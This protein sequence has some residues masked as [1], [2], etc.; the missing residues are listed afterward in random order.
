[1]TK[2]D[3]AVH[4]GPVCIAVSCS[5]RFAGDFITATIDGADVA[6]AVWMKDG[7]TPTIRYARP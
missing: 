5:N 7:A 1:M 6:H 3:P 2:I 4:A